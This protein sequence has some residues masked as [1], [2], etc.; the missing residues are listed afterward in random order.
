MWGPRAWPVTELPVCTAPH[1]GRAADPAA[2]QPCYQSHLRSSYP[3]SSG[4]SRASEGDFSAVGLHAGFL[5]VERCLNRGGKKQVVSSAASPL[6]VFCLITLS[7][8]FPLSLG[9]LHFLSLNRRRVFE[10]CSAP[11]STLSVPSGRGHRVQYWY[12]APDLG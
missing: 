6:D 8:H 2:M 12:I 9:F 3:L 10:V 11:T 5:R 1:Q 4:R 7:N